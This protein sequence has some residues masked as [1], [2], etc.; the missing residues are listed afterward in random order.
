[1]EELFH[2]VLRRRDLFFARNLVEN[3][4]GL[5]VLLHGMRRCPRNG[6]IQKHGASILWHVLDDSLSPYGVNID[7]EE[8][9]QVAGVLVAALRNHENRNSS[10]N[11]PRVAAHVKQAAIAAISVRTPSGDTNR[12][13]IQAIAPAGGIPLLFSALSDAVN[14]RFPVFGGHFDQALFIGNCLFLLYSILTTSS[15]P[16]SRRMFFHYAR[17]NPDWRHPVEHMQND[18]DLML[19]LPG[20]EPCLAV[21]R[22]TLSDF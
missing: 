19:R 11:N 22:E 20:A 21:I 10:N 4:H 1:M 17:D 12:E 5:P 15:D 2:T 13:L 9:V 16:T 7:D 3:A 6:A 8:A 18:E 14:G